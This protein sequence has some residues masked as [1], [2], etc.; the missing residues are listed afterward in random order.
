MTRKELEETAR[1][2]RALAA[3]FTLPAIAAV[4]AAA[5]ERDEEAAAALALSEWHWSDN[6]PSPE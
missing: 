4:L 5:A 3:R 2:N 1:R 6:E